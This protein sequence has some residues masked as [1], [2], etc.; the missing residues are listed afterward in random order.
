MSTAQTSV[1][2]DAS[3]SAMGIVIGLVAGLMFAAGLVFSGMTD[4]AKVIGFLNVAALFTDAVPGQWDASLAFVMGG[5]VIVT[6]IAYRQTKPN[7]E[8]SPALDANKP[9]FAQRF[10]LPTRQ[11]IDWPLISGG[12]MFGVG[13]GLGGFC[14]GPALAAWTTNSDL[15]WFVPAMLA[16]MWV[17]NRVKA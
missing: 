8:H 1:Q 15:V 12:A 3:D 13:W 10:V 5:A 6:L 17:A 7:G 2:V 14:P 4:P 11:D 9:W 16:G